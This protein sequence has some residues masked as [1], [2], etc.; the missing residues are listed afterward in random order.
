[1]NGE[2][3]LLGKFKICYGKYYANDEGVAI[4]PIFETGQEIESLTK[5]VTCTMPWMAYTAWETLPDRAVTGGRLA[6]GS[7]TYVTKI[8]HTDQ[9]LVFGYCNPKTKL[10]YN[11][12]TGPHTTTSMDIL[13]VIWIV[14]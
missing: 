9:R 13:V 12:A 10:A 3:V 2:N 6:D 1:M 14:I 11:E 4:G 7:P 8:T 5:D